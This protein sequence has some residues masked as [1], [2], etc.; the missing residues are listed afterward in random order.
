MVK[1]NEKPQV[2]PSEPTPNLEPHVRPLPLLL[3][4]DRMFKIHCN[5]EASGSAP[6]IQELFDHI[7]LNPKEEALKH[8]LDLNR[9]ST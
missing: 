3:D 8:D 4:L 9:T 7:L 1:A 6:T 2:S 5:Q